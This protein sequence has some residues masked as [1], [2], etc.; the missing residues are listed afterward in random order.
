MHGDRGKTYVR[1]K[2]LKPLKG[3]EIEARRLTAAAYETWK[4]ILHFGALFAYHLRAA[5]VAR[6]EYLLT[7]KL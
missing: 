1:K 4:S 2:R 5:T 6:S 7:G 3:R